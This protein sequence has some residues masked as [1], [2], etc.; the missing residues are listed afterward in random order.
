MTV[1]ALKAKLAELNDEM[2]VCVSAQY[3]GY[4]DVEHVEVIDVIPNPHASDR[5]GEWNMATV[6]SEIEKAVKAVSICGN[7]N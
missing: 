1:K 2:K 3:G 7:E 5:E 4:H 6:P